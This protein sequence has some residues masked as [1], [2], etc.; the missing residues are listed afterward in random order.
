GDVTSTAA[1]ANTAH[2]HIEG[3]SHKLKAMRSRFKGGK[4]VVSNGGFGGSNYLFMTAL[5]EE[6]VDRAALPAETGTIKHSV[7]NVTI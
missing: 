2:F 6:G 7:G 4:Y 5:I 1:D 3:G